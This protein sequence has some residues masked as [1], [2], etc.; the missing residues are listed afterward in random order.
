MY[1][2]DTWPKLA[3]LLYIYD[4]CLV[5]LLSQTQ[6]KFIDPTPFTDPPLYHEYTLQTSFLLNPYSAEF[7]KI[8]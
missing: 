4:C 6:S 3:I 5:M 8:Y 1:V 7:L 2:V